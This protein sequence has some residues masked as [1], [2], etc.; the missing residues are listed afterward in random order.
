M[1][2]EKIFESLVAKQD[3]NRKADKEKEEMEANR[4]KRRKKWRP[5]GRKTKKN[6]WQN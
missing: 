6:C 1:D 2:M 4:K 3:A 5:R